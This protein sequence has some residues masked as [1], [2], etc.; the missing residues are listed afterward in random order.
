MDGSREVENLH[1][2]QV[3]KEKV[4]NLFQR[5]T[6]TSPSEYEDILGDFFLPNY[7]QHHP[8]L[9]DGDCIG[10]LNMQ[11]RLQHKV[12][13]C[14]NFVL[15]ICEAIHSGKPIACY[16]LFRLEKGL[17]VEQWNIYQHIPQTDLANDNT[18][19]GFN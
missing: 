13:G 10:K 3:N 7:L 1:E 15:S 19:F 2:T 14:G 5:L 11:Y 6:T 8:Q 18:M 16:D 4:I 12:F 9:A 17:I